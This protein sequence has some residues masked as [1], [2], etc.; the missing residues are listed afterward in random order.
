MIV[1]DMRVY[2]NEEGD[3]ADYYDFYNCAELRR[4]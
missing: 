4:S 2:S 3:D 1:N